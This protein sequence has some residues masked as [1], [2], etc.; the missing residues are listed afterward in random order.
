MMYNNTMRFLFFISVILSI[1]LM[2]Y[3]V[4]SMEANVIPEPPIENPPD[5]RDAPPLPLAPIVKSNKRFFRPAPRSFV[6][7][8][9]GLPPLP[10][11]PA[12]SWPADV[13]QKLGNDVSDED[14]DIKKRTEVVRVPTNLKFDVDESPRISRE[15]MER[16]AS[17]ALEGS[18][19]NKALKHEA[20]ESGEEQKET[21]DAQTVGDNDADA[22]QQEST[23]EEK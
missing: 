11:P 17:Y 23:K 15:D 10:R 18:L 21:M 22:L 19:L 3:K 16:N 20:T 13:R 12:N 8:D 2:E 4:L 14:Y 6:Q 5:R 7:A 1:Y 9:R